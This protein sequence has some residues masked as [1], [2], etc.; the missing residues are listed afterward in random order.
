MYPTHRDHIVLHLGFKQ[1]HLITHV[2][3]VF[4]A[5]LSGYDQ[6]IANKLAVL[7]VPAKDSTRLNSDLGV[8]LSYLDKFLN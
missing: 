5:L 1:R 8:E 7:L 6:S 3:V 4:V 2:A